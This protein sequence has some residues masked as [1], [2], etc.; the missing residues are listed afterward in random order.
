MNLLKDKVE[1]TIQK[2]RETV[3][4]KWANLATKIVLLILIYL[5]IKDFLVEKDGG[6]FDFFLKDTKQNNRT[7]LMIE[8][9][10]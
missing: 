9:E 8:T 10:K 1:E 3:V 2:R 4:K 7:E 5:F 6:F